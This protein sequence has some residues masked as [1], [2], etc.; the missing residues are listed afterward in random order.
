MVKKFLF[1]TW[2]G[3]L[4]ALAFVSAVLL[5]AI[6]A[7]GYLG[8][9]G[10]IAWNVLSVSLFLAWIAACVTLLAAIFVSLFRCRW[11]R[12]LLQVLLGGLLLGGFLVAFMRAFLLGPSEDEDHFN[13]TSVLLQ[14]W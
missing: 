12:A 8:V 13:V 6:V 11:L 5:G 9:R 14:E 7:D 1:D 2:Y 4:V 10:N 3:A